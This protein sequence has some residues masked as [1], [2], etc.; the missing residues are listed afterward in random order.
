MKSVRRTI[1]ALASRASSAQGENVGYFGFSAGC[2]IL[3]EPE[4]A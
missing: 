1:Y 3:N 2:V 4:L